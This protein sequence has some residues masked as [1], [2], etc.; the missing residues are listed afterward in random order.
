MATAGRVC[1]TTK[2]GRRTNETDATKFKQLSATTKGTCQ[3][4]G[5]GANSAETEECKEQMA[6]FLV[7]GQLGV[8][9]VY[10]ESEERLQMK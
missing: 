7:V 8:L 4:N 10:E 1:G 5:A 3:A 2:S 6:S 9:S